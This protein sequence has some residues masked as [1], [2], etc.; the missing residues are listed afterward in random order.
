MISLTVVL[1]LRQCL[2]LHLHWDMER[3][4][5][6]MMI[7]LMPQQMPPQEIQ[8]MKKLSLLSDGSKSEGKDVLCVY[9]N[10]SF[11]FCVFNLLNN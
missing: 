1:Q 5:D 11:L 8:W 3:K 10:I 4:L 7:P 2:L 9:N 6:I